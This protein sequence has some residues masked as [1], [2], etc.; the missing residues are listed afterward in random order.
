MNAGVYIHIPFC[1]NRCTYCD[2]FSITH[3]N[4]KTHYINVLCKELEQRKDYLYK[5][6]IRTIYFGGGTPSLLSFADFEKIFRTL[7][8]NFLI[9]EDKEITIEVNPEDVDDR[10]LTLINHFAFNRISLGLQSFRDEELVFLGR[11]HNS[12]SAIKA[13]ENF[14]KYGYQNISIDLIYGLPG[15][16]LKVWETTIQQAISLNVQHISAYHLTYEKNTRIDR[17]RQYGLIRP[18]SEIKSLKM[19][20]NLIDKLLTAGFEHY[21]ISNFA[22]RTHRSKHNVGYWNGSYYLG[23]G[24]AAHSYNGKT[25]QWN[26]VGVRGILHYSPEIEIIDDTTAYNDFILT[27]LRTTKGIDLNELVSFCGEKKKLYCLNQAEKHVGNHL[28]KI[29]SNHL[30]LTRKGLFIS[31]SIMCDLLN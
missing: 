11:R 27:R 22:L 4:C 21:E 18:I 3:L 12:H 7:Q 24:A 30:Q 17:M 1:K 29:V 26:R 14:Q 20:E 5:H 8:K 31:D 25:R 16:S 2:F 13:V 28:L 6:N 9:D 19:F 10:F 23:I 15:Q